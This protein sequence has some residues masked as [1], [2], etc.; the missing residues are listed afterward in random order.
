[1]SES[2]PL[3][4]LPRVGTDV[5]E[6]VLKIVR[7]TVA[8]RREAD[9]PLSS[10]AVRMLAMSIG[11]CDDHHQ[12]PDPYGFARTILPFW[13]WTN[14]SQGPLQALI[15]LDQTVGHSWRWHPRQMIS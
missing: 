13:H 8:A 11:N 2:T 1:M 12:T 5:D 7:Y 10:P 3:E 15:S 9:D 14:P 6:Q 4:P